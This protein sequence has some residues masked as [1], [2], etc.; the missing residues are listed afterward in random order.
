MERFEKILVYSMKN[1]TDEAVE[2]ACKMVGI[3]HFIKTLPKGYETILNDKTSLSA[4]QR[5]LI[6]IARAMVANSPLLILDEA[7][8]SVDIT[9]RDLDSRSYG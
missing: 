9:Y 2:Q 3:H 7:T 5:Q 4:G 6:T 8:S 1:V